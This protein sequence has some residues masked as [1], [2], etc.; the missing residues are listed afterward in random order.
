RPTPPLA[1]RWRLTRAALALPRV[2]LQESEDLVQPQLWLGRIAPRSDHAVHP[3]P[4]LL[5]A[6]DHCPPPGGGVPTRIG[7]SVARAAG[8][9]E[10]RAR[11][12]I[13][14]GI[15]FRVDRAL[16][17]P[18][19]VRDELPLLLLGRRL[20]AGHHLPHQ[21]AHVAAALHADHH[22]VDDDRPLL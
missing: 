22:A 10:R 8:K 4:V 1:H 12:L 21:L 16:A 20:D 19:Q 11:W 6:P 7:E 17:V 13:E 9:L 18:L 14:L 2:L 5:H 15:A 3:R